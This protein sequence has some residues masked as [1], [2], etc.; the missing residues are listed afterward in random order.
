MVA[1]A[2]LIILSVKDIVAKD[3]GKKVILKLTCLQMALSDMC[4]AVSRQIIRFFGEEVFKLYT[5][6]L[7][8]L[9]AN[10]RKFFQLTNT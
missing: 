6:V 3:M 1:F 4:I 10:K 5:F 7:V 2:D 8:I 9:L